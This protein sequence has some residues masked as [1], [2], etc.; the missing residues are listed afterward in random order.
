M[1]YIRTKPAKPRLVI[2]VI[3]HMD[4]HRFLTGFVFGVTFV[5]LLVTVMFGKR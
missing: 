5:L 2:R 4:D 3:D 1:R